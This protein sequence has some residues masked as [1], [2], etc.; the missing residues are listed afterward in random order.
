MSLPSI[1][2]RVKLTEKLRQT[3]STAVSFQVLVVM[4]QAQNVS[5]I[6]ISQPTFREPSETIH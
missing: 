4:H 3:P 6:F 5:G 1:A 2:E